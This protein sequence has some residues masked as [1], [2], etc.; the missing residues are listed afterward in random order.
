MNQRNTIVGAPIERVEDYRFLR[1]EGVYVDD[2]DLPNQLH[3]VI[4]RSSV[5]HGRI[6]NIDAS[7]ALEIPGV[8]AVVTAKDIGEQIPVIPMRLQPLE[9]VKP[10]RQPVIAHQKVRYVGEPVAVILAD[11][12]AIAEDALQSVVVEIDELPIVHDYVESSADNTLL[13]ESMGTNLGKRFTGKKGDVDKAFAQADYVRREKLSVQRHM[14]LPLELR[15]LLAVWNS[16]LEQMKVYGA[17]KVLFFN[18][19]AL[20]AMM[21]IEESQIEL[22]ENDIGGGFGA[23]GEFYPEDFLIPFSSRLTGRPVKWSEDRREN[24][25][26]L[27]HA[28]EMYADL[29]I[30]CSRDGIILGIR[31]SV[32]VDCGAYFRSNGLTPPRNVAQFTSGPY[33]I[34]NILIDSNALVT[35]KTPCGTYRAPGRFE[36]SFFVERMVEIAARELRLDPVDMR[37]RNLI[38]EGAMPYPLAT[39]QHIDP[40]TD[41]DCDSGDYSLTFER[42]LKEFNWEEKV[43]LQGRLIDGRYH[44]VS[45]GAFI[46]GGAAGPREAARIAIEDNGTIGVYVGS[47]ALGQGLETVLGQIAADAIGVP[48]DRIKIFHG[49]T[50]YVTEGFGSYHSRST[51]VGGS[52]IVVAAKD[53]QDALKVAAAKRL[54]CDQSEIEIEGFD[55][56]GPRH[57]RIGISEFYR[58]GISIERSFANTKHTYAYG[59]HCAHVAVDPG[60][61][62]V[63]M[64]DYVAVEDV[65]KIINPLTLHG[66]VIGAVVQGLGSAFMEHLQYDEHGQLLTG[67]LADY[68]IPSA[69]DFPCIRGFSMETHPCPNNPLGAKG[70]GEGGIIAVGGVAANAVSAALSSLGVDV[71][72]LPMTPPNIWELIDQKQKLVSLPGKK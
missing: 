53:F 5:A 34:E 52:A 63:E 31:G 32:D 70:A 67:S 58:D 2:L 29:E 72:S 43:K 9:E 7:A 59:A 41:T 50:S 10:Y 39:M 49:S 38:P 71:T 27:N 55:V 23:R 61:G 6:R 24:L 65:G 66:Q 26:A 46:E 4:L 64:L 19:R 35:N 14:A 15:G 11:S 30:A 20:A 68:V 42:C 44:G 60:T 13:F 12:A 45:V 36:G 8:C 57:R 16:Q 54:D 56:V 25:M 17:G 22:V 48:F 47:S 21:R 40:Y 33:K 51:V 37:R 3:A 69:D 62:H 18:R 1:G 28:R